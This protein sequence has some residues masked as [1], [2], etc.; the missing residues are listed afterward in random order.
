MLL[1][2]LLHTIMSCM[3]LFYPLCLHHCLLQDPFLCLAFWKYKSL[4]L[5]IFFKESMLCIC[6]SLTPPKFN[7]DKDH[8][9]SYKCLWY[10]CLWTQALCA[11][12]EEILHMWWLSNL[13][14]CCERIWSYSCFSHDNSFLLSMIGYYYLLHLHFSFGLVLYCFCWFDEMLVGSNGYGFK[15]DFLLSLW[16]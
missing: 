10:V 11:K 13:I 4:Q 3:V 7:L 6:T 1:L 9:P 15:Y 5:E 8:N 16:I 2:F 14:H 12:K